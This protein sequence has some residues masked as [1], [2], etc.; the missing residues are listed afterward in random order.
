MAS[1]ESAS[2]MAMAVIDLVTITQP[3]FIRAHRCVGRPR[4][5]FGE[6]WV[7]EMLGRHCVWAGC[8]LVGDVS[9]RLCDDSGAQWH[10]CPKFEITLTGVLVIGNKNSDLC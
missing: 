4:Q 1:R 6:G 10:H 3:L 5:P 2:V 8:L 9:P 7:V